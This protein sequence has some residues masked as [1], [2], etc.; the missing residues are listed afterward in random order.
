MKKLFLLPLLPVPQAKGYHDFYELR[1]LWVKY[2]TQNHRQKKPGFLPHGR[3][4]KLLKDTVFPLLLLRVYWRSPELLTVIQ[5]LRIKSSNLLS[6]LSSPK[7]K[8]PPNSR[9][10]FREFSPLTLLKAIGAINKMLSNGAKPVN[11]TGVPLHV[12]G[13]V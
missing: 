8:I 10:L 5:K 11:K 7:N 4:E 2:E 3:Q 9:Y 13:G 6:L 1:N 12:F